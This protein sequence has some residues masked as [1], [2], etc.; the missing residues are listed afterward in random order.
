M[1]LSRLSSEETLGQLRIKPMKFRMPGTKPKRS[2]Q[3]PF[4]PGAF[5]RKPIPRF[6]DRASAAAW[7]LKNRPDL[8]T[9][10]DKKILAPKPLGL[11]VIT[12][13][14]MIP[15]VPSQ[16]PEPTPEARLMPEAD[17]E[18]IPWKDKKF[19][20]LKNPVALGVYGGSGLLLLIGGGALIRRG[21]KKRKK[22]R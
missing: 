9:S 7:K 19:W 14:P 1:S 15:F 21:M 22:K 2:G 16:F 6:R 13:V 4:K 5:R 18:E 12:P 8:L 10:A 20:G 3:R 17:P 11:D